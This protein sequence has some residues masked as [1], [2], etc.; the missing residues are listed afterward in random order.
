M[1]KVV[2]LYRYDFP[3][4][5]LNLLPSECETCGGEIEITET[6]SMLMCTNDKCL[7]R[8]TQRLVALL[9]DLGVKN[10]GESKCR[11]FLET[12]D[13]SNPY[14][15]LAYTPQLHGAIYEGAS[16]EFSQKVYEDI[17][18]VKTMLLWEYVKIGNM[19]GIRDSA[20]KL[21]SDYDD[22]NVFYADL[23]KGGI[24]YVQ[25]KLSI[26]V[27]KTEILLNTD[28]EA[29]MYGDEDDVEE[30][31]IRAL[32]VYDTL[33]SNKDDLLNTIGFVNIKKLT[34]AVVN[35]CISTSVG[36]PFGS[37]K[38][39]V[40]QMNNDYGDK[41][42]L[43]F[44]GSVTKECQFLIWAKEGSPTSKVKKVESI[45]AKREGTDEKEIAVMTGL[46]FKEYLEKL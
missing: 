38:D 37:K 35:I 9:K 11:Q 13:I 25:D 8:V 18:K 6:L 33:M 14:E 46:E 30:V 12:F 5:F 31:S 16:L 20:R 26:G 22:L 27:N 29:Y 43:N 45:N 21:L 40:N 32:K 15:I 17:Q 42:H 10:M 36:A 3:H 23:E 44:L 34:T 24:A 41:V 19:S 28:N 4:E 39:F 2:E 7:D 1:L